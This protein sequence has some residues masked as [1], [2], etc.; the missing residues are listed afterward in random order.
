[1]PDWTFQ[2][3]FRPAMVA[4]GVERG[5]QIALNSMGL[6]SRLPLGTRVIQLMGHTKPDA[7]LSIE[8]NELNLPTQVGLGC[9]LDPHLL[10]TRAFAEFGFGFLEVGPIKTHPPARPGAVHLDA[11]G[12]SFRLDPPRAAISPAAARDRLQA[13]GLVSLPVFARVEP[14]T[15]EEAI[16][17]VRLLDKWVAG[18]VAPIDYL[19]NMLIALD[20]R[21]PPDGHRPV[22]LARVDAESWRDE[23]QRDRCT[24]AFRDGHLS[25]VVVGVPANEDTA[26]QIGKVGFAEALEIVRSVRTELGPTSIVVGS[27]GIHSPADA[28][29]YLEA[30]AD[31]LQVDSGMFFAGPGLPKRINE[32]ILY[33]RQETD[34]HGPVMMPRPGSESW[35][36]ALLMGLSMLLGGMMAMLI[37]TTRVVMPYDETMGGLSREQLSKV[38]D[39]LLPF[40]THDRVSLAGTMLAVGILYTALACRGLRRGMHWAYLSVV[41]SALA[42]F[43]SFFTF[44]GFGYFDPFHAFVTAILFQFLVMTIHA[45]LPARHGMASPDLWND[46]RWRANQWGQLLFVVHGAVLIV[47][48]LVIS[49]V[50]MTSVFVP[51]DLEFMQ[52]C[53]AA[54][55]GAHPGLAPLVA[56]DRATFGG[57]LISCGVATLLPALW[58]FGR[59]QAWLWWA[60]ML[61]GNLAY[62][63]A[64][65][66]HWCVGYHSLKHLL[67][68]YGGLAWLWAGGVASYWFLAARDEKLEG[69]WRERLSRAR[70]RGGGPFGLHD[71][72]PDARI[73]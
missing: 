42:G 17:I 65:L 68:A 12:E 38:N 72:P 46:W 44:L 69:E 8:R 13:A 10:A 33:R 48:G 21:N 43:A 11:D 14:S 34:G 19:G 40:M 37:A 54:L 63:S 55:I 59:G 25:G 64:I 4:I 62:S 9:G 56:H 58:G 53:A 57:M 73:S 22:A 18:Y 28:L 32:A 30:G 5:R 29:D 2:T 45:R 50:G 41:I 60:L 27:V 6:L 66:V 24:R 51:E 16:E 23:T 7:R 47:A 31:L 70:P 61:A 39:R 52:T 1:M 49:I 20:G 36:W 67:P 71:L 15:P 3:V 26:Q 35:F